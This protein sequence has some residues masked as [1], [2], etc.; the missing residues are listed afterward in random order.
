MAEGEK[1]EKHNTRCI[2]YKPTN[3]NMGRREKIKEEER[4]E[5]QTHYK[6]AAAK[7]KKITDAKR[8]MKDAVRE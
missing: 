6:T 5:E 4:T 1:S 2:R 7:I 8:R 3:R